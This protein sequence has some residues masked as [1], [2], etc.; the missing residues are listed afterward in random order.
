MLIGN[1]DHQLRYADATELEGKCVAARDGEVATADAGGQFGNFNRHADTTLVLGSEF[2]DRV[3]MRMMRASEQVQSMDAFDADELPSDLQCDVVK[4]V[5]AQRHQGSERLWRLLSSQRPKPA[6]LWANQRISSSTEK[7]RAAFE[8]ILLAR[9]AQERIDHQFVGE[10]DAGGIVDRHDQDSSRI[11]FAEVFGAE[12]GR[13]DNNCRRIQ[14]PSFANGGVQIVSR[15]DFGVAVRPL[16]ASAQDRPGERLRLESAQ[17]IGAATATLHSAGGNQTLIEWRPTL[18]RGAVA[19]EKDWSTVHVS[20]SIPLVGRK[21]N[22]GRDTVERQV[23]WRANRTFK[24]GI[25]FAAFGKQLPAALSE[26]DRRVRVEWKP[27]RRRTRD[28]RTDSGS[29]ERGGENG[30]VR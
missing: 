30:K 23:L 2:T 25:E 1:R 10:A 7:L 26:I 28:Y 4:V 14:S 8:L 13:R 17:K 21:T 18:R 20:D 15:A 11:Q 5:I 19:S 27:A 12:L 3:E 9:Q 22:R 29:G 6:N 16:V 24:A